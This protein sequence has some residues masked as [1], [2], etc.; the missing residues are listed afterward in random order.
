M[1][2]APSRP[3]RKRRRRSTPSDRS[4]AQDAS[5]DHRREALRGFPGEG[6]FGPGESEPPVCGR[7][8]GEGRKGG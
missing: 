7:R 3:R 5:W 8:A 6:V 4:T 1:D 2:T